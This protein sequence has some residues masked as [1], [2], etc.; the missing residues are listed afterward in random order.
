MAESNEPILVGARDFFRESESHETDW[1]EQW[2]DDMRFRALDQ[3]T[4]AARAA[5]NV[6]DEP[7]RPCM[8]IDQT[9]Q[10]VRQVIN[11]AR[12]SPPALRASPVDDKADIR[13]AEDMQGLF[14]HIERVSRAQKA[15]LWALEGAVTIGRGWFR[16]YADE[17]DKVRG[18]YEP[19]IARIANWLSVY[20]DP[21]STEL[22][23]SDMSDAMLIVDY[24]PGAFKRKWPKA[25]TVGSWEGGIRGD[26]MND[27]IRV[28]EW[29][30][31][32]ERETVQIL[33]PDGSIVMPDDLRRVNQA[34]VAQGLPE[35]Q[36][37]REKRTAERV[38]TI[39]TVTQ[40]E[41]LDEYEFHAPYVG[42]I[43]VYGNERYTQDGRNL[44][45]MIRAAKDPGRLTNYI[46]SSMAEAANAQIKT[47]WVLAAES[48]DGYE[49][50]W[51]KANSSSQAYLLYNHKDAEREALPAPTRINID[52]QLP[53]YGQLMQ[54]GHHLL[55]TSIGMYQASVG[56]QSNETS[57][58][59]IARRKSESDVGT[60]H[61]IDNLSDSIQHAGRIIMSM[62]PKVYDTPRIARI[63]GEDGAPS[64][65]R[66]DASQPQAFAEDRDVRG[67]KIHVLNPTV[68]EYDV[69]VTVGPSY[70]SQREETAATLAE[71]YGRNPALMQV[72]GDIYFENLNFPGAQQIAK[73][74]KA[75][76]PDAI[77]A[78]DDDT[79]VPAEIQQMMV[80]MQQAMAQR[81]QVIAAGAQE[82]QKLI[83]QAKEARSAA[84][85]AAARV[86]TAEAQMNVDRERL[87]RVKAD[88]EHERQLLQIAQQQASREAARM[89][90]D[91]NRA[92]TD[93]EARS[94]EVQARETEQ[95]GVKDMLAQLLARDQQRPNRRVVHIRDAN[96]RIVES[97]LVEDELQP[98]Q[99]A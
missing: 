37:F 83:D 4:E 68:G 86:K 28:A 3:W 61:Y 38:C 85:V 78:L 63:L 56:A 12:L 31:V 74:L 92:A 22:D 71:L 17:V 40:V 76:L 65:V 99:S 25:A 44:F 18:Y 88:I 77:K 1:R 8:T 10:Y 14:R 48:V 52:V 69:H 98:E 72:S 95:H 46:A 15:Y 96:N 32:R 59:A 93:V 58:V 66:I 30:S 41:V 82:A 19:R 47:P 21:F 57:G 16:V 89:T 42:L 45:G 54:M 90:E 53:G 5:R 60:Y 35:V 6:P 94:G 13:V 9:D 75:V 36:D 91:I 81:E 33:L 97:R 70:A 64:Q 55:Q 43:P 34:L 49:D 73:R 11:D 87:E 67:D 7:P 2:H 23:G 84:E 24:A 62:I 51:A 39:R 26:W 80:R 27:H 50:K 20:G 29:H 79:E